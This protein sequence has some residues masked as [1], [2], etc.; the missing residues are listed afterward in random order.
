MLATFVW[1]GLAVVFGLAE[2][3]APGLICLWFCLGAAVSFVVSF[4]VPDLLVQIIVFVVSSA[5]MLLALRPFMRKRV[6]GT[7]EDALTNADTYVGREVLVTQG[8]PAGAGRTG[9]VKLADVSWL[10]RTADASALASGT[11]ARVSAVESTVLVVE[12]LVKTES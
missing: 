1:L 3:A 12:P 5:A 11:R 10:A 4:F 6:K 9:R 8:I 2:A 7:P